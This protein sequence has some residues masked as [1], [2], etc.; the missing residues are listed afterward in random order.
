M[1]GVNH[2]F[3]KEKEMDLKRQNKAIV[4]GICCLLLVMVMAIPAMA[5]MKAEGIAQAFRWRNIGPANMS[6]RISD[7]EALDE[8]FTFVLIGSASGGVWKSVNAGITWEPIFDTYGAASIGD[9]AIFQKDPNIIWVGT[10]EKNPRNS[11]AWGDGIY[12]STDSGKTFTHMG[13][14][15]THSISKII[16]H[17][18]D[19]DTVFVAAGGHLWGFTGSRGLFK[20]TDGGKTWKQIKSGLPDDGKTG[21]IDL[22]MDPSNPDTLYVG[23]WQRIRRPYR[24]DSGGPNG[25]IFKSTD[26]G[27]SWNKLTNGL[28]QGDTGKIG[29]AICRSKPDVLMAF[30]EH[31]FQPAENLPDGTENPEYNDMTKLGSGIYRSEDGGASWQY[32]NR[33]NNR[34]FY[35]SH[36]YLNPIDD[37]I[38][39]VV[40]GSYLISYDGGKTLERQNTGIHGDY[41]ALWSDPKNKDRYYIGNDGGSAL[42]HDQGKNYIFFD[43]LAVSQFYAVGADNRDPYYV[44]GGLQD[45][46]TWGGPSNSR[47]RQGI[48]T[49]HWFNVG[50]G[51]GFYAQ[52]D[53][54]DWSTVYVESQQGSISRVDINTRRGQSIRPRKN[55]IVNYDDYVTQNIL[56]LQREAGWG[57]DNPFR[58]NWSSPIFVSQHHPGTLYFGGNFFFKSGDR[59]DSWEIIS[60]DLTTQDP[61]KIKR[62]TGGLTSDVTGAENHCSIVTISESPLTPDV[63]WAGTDDGNVQI[64]Q[65]GGKNWTNVRPN[66]KNV[67]QEIWVSRVE[68][69]HFKEGTC[70]VTFDGHRSDNFKPWVFKTEDYGKTW[71][72]ISS[73]LPDGQVAHVIREDPINRNL[74]FLG[75][76]FGIFVSTSGGQKWERFMNNLPTVAVHDILIHPL[77]KDII[78]GTHGRGIWICDDITALQQMTETLSSSAVQLFSPRTATQWNSF[79]RGGSRGQFLFSGEN[80]PHG[81]L[82]HYFLGSDVKEATLEISDLQGEIKLTVQLE[83]TPGINRYIWNYS[84]NP[85]ELNEAEKELLDKYV[86]T[87]DREERSAIGE[88]LQKSLEDRG[89]RFGGINRREN[90]LNSIPAGPGSYKVTLKAG[91]K[92]MTKPLAV[93]QDPIVK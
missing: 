38:V 73:D 51:D 6:G 36:I 68:A 72:A 79:S 60:P 71:M 84:F 16:T 19:P 59:G 32:M 80:P 8:D 56:D 3:K 87:T 58:F 9:V 45:N 30:V 83:N 20:T 75:T 43:N 91:A 22:I 55:N 13:L 18:E 70:Y 67:P 1:N 40:T 48:L 64:T 29:L 65:D 23:F 17:P 54:N 49:D 88:Q 28:P 46:G 26:S 63:L 62:E 69:S 74:L 37:K 33:Y 11:I 31:G 10:G 41:H 35:Y 50:G 52:A 66:F 82:I 78:I 25:G 57:E 93:R 24:F 92:M 53:P 85:P 61:V 42:T 12:K 27:N 90:T 86:K 14:E 39:Y 34:P 44:Y 47:D 2:F 81:A 77:Y 21:A 4:I 76:E 15:D 89:Q 5:Q 7:I